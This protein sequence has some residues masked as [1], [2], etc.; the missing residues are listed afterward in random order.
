VIYTGELAHGDA[1]AVDHPAQSASEALL[2]EQQ[3]IV[4]FAEEQA[5]GYATGRQRLQPSCGWVAMAERVQDIPGMPALPALD[6]ASFPCAACADL[7]PIDLH[8][9]S[10]LPVHLRVE[11]DGSHHWRRA[12]HGSQ[13]DPGRGA[14]AHQ[15][16][17]GMAALPQGARNLDRVL[18][19]AEVVGASWGS[20]AVGALAPAAQVDTHAAVAE[21]REIPR[22]LHPRP[23]RP[24]VAL[25]TAVE[26]HE[27]RTGAIGIL[28]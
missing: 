14:Q 10:G 18:H 1:A 22:V 21:C 6:C 11:R 15:D 26:Q 28:G 13:R 20:A 9:I 19:S 4:R 8:R 5:D 25:R 16:D 3:P 23:P 24:H 17:A 27:R 2:Q 7:I 12:D